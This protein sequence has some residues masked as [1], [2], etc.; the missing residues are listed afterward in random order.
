MRNVL[1]GILGLGLLLPAEAGEQARTPV[2]TLTVTVGGT[3][4]LRMTTKKPISKV[5]NERPEVARVT[6]MMDD[7]TTVLVTGLMPGQTRITLVAAD[8][9]KEVWDGR[10]RPARR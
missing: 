3:I 6:A 8:G 7:P 5:V 1:A 9:E 10:K 4:R 2:R